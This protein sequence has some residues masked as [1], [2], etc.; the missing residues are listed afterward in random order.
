MTSSWQSETGHLVCHWSASVQPVQYDPSWIPKN[1]D[2][3][4]SY[5]PP[6]LDFASHSPLGGATWFQ[7]D[8]AKHR[9]Q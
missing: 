4:T 9:C 5:F 3:Q 6:L 8:P 1:S 7:P 2:I